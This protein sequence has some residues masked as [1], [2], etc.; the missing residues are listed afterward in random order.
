MRVRNEMR[1]VGG[2][3]RGEVMNASSVVEADGTSRLQ[4]SDRDNTILL[5]DLV[6]RKTRGGAARE[7]ATHFLTNE[8]MIGLSALETSYPAEP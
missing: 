7:S 5:I 2:G 8:T 1:E 4:K 6:R 3:V